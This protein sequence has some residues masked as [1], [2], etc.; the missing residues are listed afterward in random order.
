MGEIEKLF[1]LVG[2]IN[3]PWQLLG[4]VAVLGFTFGLL[5]LLYKFITS[6]F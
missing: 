3:S 5:W 4:F 6:I 1:E 2:Q